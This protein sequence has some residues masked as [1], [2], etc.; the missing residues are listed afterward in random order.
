MKLHSRMILCLIACSLLA[1]PAVAQKPARLSW[2]EFAK[3]PNRVQSF[4]NAVAVM[5]TRSAG[6]R[7]SVEFRKSWEYWASMHGY[8]G[9]TAKSGTVDTWRKNNGLTSPRYDAAFA[10]VVNTTPPDQVAQTVWDQ[11]QH[12][13]NYFFPWHRL[14]LYYFEQVLQDA[15]GDPSLRLP[16][17]DYTDPAQLAMP[18]EFTSPAY[19]NTQGQSVP[20]PLFESRRAVG[21]EPPGTRKLTS[22]DTDI[23]LALDNPNLL[24]TTDASG[25]EVQGYQRTIELSP[26]GYA[27]CAVMGCRATVMGAVPYSS[28]DPIFW[29][30]HANIDRLWD[31][32]MSISGH[33]N[34]SS[35]MSQSF[36]YVDR[37]GALVTKQVRNLFDGSLIDYV[38]QQPS[39]CARV[40]AQPEAVAA[41]PQASATAVTAARR[42]LARA[43]LIGESTERLAI[44]A[45]LTRRRISLPATASL[46]HPRQFAL[47]EQVQLPVATEL[48]L[49]GVHFDVHPG[50]S[51]GVSLERVDNGKRSFVGTL[52]FFSDEPAGAAHHA[53][54]GT[55]VFDATDALRELGLE[56]TGTLNVNVVIEEVDEPDDADFDPATANLVVDEIEFHV[57]RDL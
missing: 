43:V 30:H 4:R 34:P 25:N 38:Y 5:K 16:Y 31:C 6:D 39:N 55:R 9:E 20:N 21:W 32:W 54:S 56:G 23:D 52:S 44:N 42:A 57:K 7:T 50:R 37:N 26:H 51:F 14:F 47:R 45:P 40:T 33:K 8:F 35:I 22:K 12:G 18:A 17:W 48:I 11:C 28:N 19:T 41:A 46:S 27:H 49:R 24:S 3:D 1:L 2:Q 36:S 53:S 29:I 15:A 13:T 10:G